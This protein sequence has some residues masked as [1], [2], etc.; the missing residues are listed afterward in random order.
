LREDYGVTHLI[1]ETRDFTDSEHV[2]EYFSPWRSRIA[3][4]LAE[5]K[6]KEFL[7]SPSLRERAAVF[8]GD[9]FILLD[10]ARLP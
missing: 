7:L 9:G 4:R 1:V 6:G 3:A 2:P 8:N 10:L 5:I